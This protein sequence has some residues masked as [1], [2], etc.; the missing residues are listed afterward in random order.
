MSRSEHNIFYNFLTTTALSWPYIRG[1]QLLYYAGVWVALW[2][3]AVG[4]VWT[5]L[6]PVRPTPP[7][8]YCTRRCSNNLYSA[9]TNTG[10]I[11]MFWKRVFCRKS[12][13]TNVRLCW[14]FHIFN[15][16]DD[17]F[18][19]PNAGACRDA[20]TLQYTKRH[21]SL[22]KL[23][24]KMAC[25]MNDSAVVLRKMTNWLNSWFVYTISIRCCRSPDRFSG[26]TVYFIPQSA[27][28]IPPIK[29]C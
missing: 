21:H 17:T 23:N 18:Y 6:L 2:L 3:S 8:T 26:T 20:L 14:C 25:E 5:A 16:T 4:L 1:D 7:G 22:I 9:T 28:I 11:W 12:N 13:T 15:K 24:K 29:P 10:K 27:M 19:T